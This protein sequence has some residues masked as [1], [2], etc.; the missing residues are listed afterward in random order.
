MTGN[1][2]PLATQSLRRGVTINR[3]TIDTTG[4]VPLP[5]AADILAR[6]ENSNDNIVDT[7]ADRRSYSSISVVSL[8]DSQYSEVSEEE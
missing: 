3:H 5:A 4:V 8:P 7:E 1:I 2:A 6:N